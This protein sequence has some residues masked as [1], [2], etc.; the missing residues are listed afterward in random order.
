MEN[1]VMGKLDAAHRLPGVPALLLEEQ[2]SSCLG[3]SWAHG[4]STRVLHWFQLLC[5]SSHREKD[6]PRS[7]G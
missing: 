5:W 7:L 2:Q 6:N 1:K 3:R 4:V